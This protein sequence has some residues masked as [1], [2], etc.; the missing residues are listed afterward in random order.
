MAF[1]ICGG[2]WEPLHAPNVLEEDFSISISISP[3]NANPTQW[4]REWLTIAGY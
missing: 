4:D 2:C 3:L 1:S